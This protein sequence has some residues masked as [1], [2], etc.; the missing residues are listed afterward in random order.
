VALFGHSKG[1]VASA[2]LAALD[3]SQAVIEFVP[4]GIILR[5]NQRFLDA[6]GYTL[7]E[8]QGRH[9]NLFVTPDYAGSPDYARFWDELANVLGYVAGTAGAVEQ[10]SM[11]T[12]EMSRAMRK[13]AGNVSAIN[14]NMTEISSAVQQVGATVNATRDAANVL[15]R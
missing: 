1:W 3:R 5:A 10:Q 13:T 14:D 15:V 6:M 11:V 4:D 2:V 8:M 9:H 12:K 7:P